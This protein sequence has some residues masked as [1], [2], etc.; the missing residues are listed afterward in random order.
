M[1]KVWRERKMKVREKY[2]E[3]WVRRAPWK[4]PMPMIRA[5]RPTKM[6]RM[7]NNSMLGSIIALA[8]WRVNGNCENFMNL[9]LR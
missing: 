2:F 9:R 4:M 8:G 5:D 7:V 1:A 6:V 3:V